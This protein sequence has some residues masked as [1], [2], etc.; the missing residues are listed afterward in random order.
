MLRCS[1]IPKCIIIFIP[2]KDYTEFDQ[3]IISH[4]TK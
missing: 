1:A 4:I 2:D 3:Y